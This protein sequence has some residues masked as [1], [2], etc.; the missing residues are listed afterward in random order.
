MNNIDAGDKMIRNDNG[1]DNMISKLLESIPP[2]QV[3]SLIEFSKS[4]ESS[5]F[6]TASDL[7]PVSCVLNE[8][9]EGANVKR[10]TNRATLSLVSVR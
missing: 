9:K 4:I 10:G 1:V 3:R 5:F 6:V 8:R 2:A 7:R